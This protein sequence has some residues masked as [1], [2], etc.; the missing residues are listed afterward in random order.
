LPAWCLPCRRIDIIGC[1]RASNRTLLAAFVEKA[2]E[3]PV[4]SIPEQR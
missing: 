2:D 1:A 3:T 4:G